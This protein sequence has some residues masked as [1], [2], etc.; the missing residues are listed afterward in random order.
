MKGEKLKILIISC[1]FPPLNLISSLRAYSWAK[2]WS[3]MGH[4]VCVLTVKNEGLEDPLVLPID[5]D[6]RMSIRIEEIPLRY[7]RF[8]T[9]TKRIEIPIRDNPNNIYTRKRFVIDTKIRKFV[10]MARRTFRNLTGIDPTN[11]HLWILPAVKKALEIYS[12]W[13]FDIM[14]STYSPPAAHITAGILKRKLGIFWVADYRDLWYGNHY[15]YSGK[16][17]FSFFKKHIED[18][19]VKKADFFTTVSDIMKEKLISRFGNKVITIENGFDTEE[20]DTK[21]NRC[22]FPH[23]GKIRLVYTGRLYTGKQDPAPLLEA[24][25]ILKRRGI[26]IEDKLEI[27]FYGFPDV[28]LPAMITK[29]NLKDIVKTHDIVDRETVLQIQREASLL[30]FLDWQDTTAGVFTGKLFEYMYA[31]TPVLNISVSSDTLPSKLIE[32]AGIGITVVNSAEKIADIIETLI[33]GGKLN[34]SPS[35]EVLE[36][37]TRKRLAEKMLEGIVKHFTKY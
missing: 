31:G 25:S 24:I 8:I 36:K 17:P 23:D 13:P 35:Q 14:V 28:Y 15:Y 19:F 26:P 9:Y 21:R 7:K 18:F 4:E 3:R 6:V 11:P 27:I 5:T 22:I 12:Q 37:Y 20:L 2:Y 16:W 1:Y 30:V 33:K 10:K 34:Y 29:R 32:A